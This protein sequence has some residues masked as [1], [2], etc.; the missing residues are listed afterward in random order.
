MRIDILNARRSSRGLRNRKSSWLAWLALLAISAFVAVSGTT[1]HAAEPDWPQR[2]IMLILPY[3]PGGT[4]DFQARIM[5]ARLSDRLGQS[6]VIQNKSGAAGI[7][8]TEYVVHSNPDGYTLFFASSAQTTSVP[9]TEKVNY[10]LDDLIPI[11]ASGNGPM[12]LAVNANMPVHSLKEFIDYVKSNPGKFTYSSAGTGSVAHLVGALFVA[13]A[14]LQALHVPFRGAG[15]ATAALISDQV[16]FYFGNSADLLQHQK[17]EH[18]RIIAVS[19]PE[20]MPQLPNVPTVSEV[21]R[22]FAMSA[23]QGFLA[24]AH[25]PQPIIDRLAKEIASIAKEPGIVAKLAAAGVEA[26]S[27]TPAQFREIIQNEQSIY[28]EAVRAAGLKPN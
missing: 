18:I 19:T 9:M 11:S 25:T 21:I 1:A 20:R 7:V 28:A 26:T 8:A 24:P 2:P 6:V 4:I 15:P 23:W 16:D 3:P 17:D 12:I 27:T 13:R 5:G 10:K 22:G 14:G